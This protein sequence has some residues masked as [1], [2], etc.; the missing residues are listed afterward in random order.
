VA[1]R[2]YVF[3]GVAALGLGGGLLFI[4]HAPT[5]LDTTGLATLMLPDLD[6]DRTPDKLQVLPAGGSEA[7][8]KL[9]SSRTG[10]EHEILTIPAASKLVFTGIA[11]RWVLK[12]PQGTTRLTVKLYEPGGGAPPN[13]IVLAGNQGKRYVWVER[14]FLKLDALTVIPGFS[15]GLVM[16]GDRRQAL[17]A[18]GGAPTAQGHWNVPLSPPLRYQVAF[19]PKARVSALTCD[20]QAMHTNTG[21][22]RG[23]D[24]ATLKA[25]Y[26]GAHKGGKWVSRLYG[27]TASLDASGQVRAL[28]ID[29]PGNPERK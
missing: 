7:V 17:E 5:P 20:S 21:V 9:R 11:P 18:I 8:V 2:T 16:L 24:L 15:S 28:T 29:R 19:D 25:H 6:G 23:A 1:F 26:P 3:V 12:D 4:G 22:G 27:L 13:L 14:G 10:F